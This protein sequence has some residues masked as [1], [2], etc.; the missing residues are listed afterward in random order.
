MLRSAG[1]P[2]KHCTKT[3]SA[4]GAITASVLFKINVAVFYQ[5]GHVH[6]KKIPLNQAIRKV[7]QTAQALIPDLSFGNSSNEG[8]KGET[9]GTIKQWNR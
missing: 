5:C 6:K 9:V 1:L 2:Q 7:G 8:S 3:T 4:Q